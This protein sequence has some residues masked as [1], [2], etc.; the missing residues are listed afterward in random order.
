VVLPVLYKFFKDYADL[1]KG[2]LLLAADVKNNANSIQRAITSSSNTARAMLSRAIAATRALGLWAM[3]I[4]LVTD[5]LGTL[6]SDYVLIGILNSGSHPI[7]GSLATGPLVMLVLLGTAMTGVG[8]FVAAAIAG[9]KRVLHG[10]CVGGLALLVSVVVLV[11][12]PAAFSEYPRWFIV[13]Q[14]CLQVPVGA[15]GGFASKA[16]SL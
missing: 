13:V 5:W 7:Q 2:F 3:L 15:L 10:L 1:R 9:R 12:R 11:A 6:F 14:L 16:L 8:G 4:G